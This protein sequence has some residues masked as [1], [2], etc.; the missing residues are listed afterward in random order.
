MSMEYEVTVITGKQ[1]G[2]G[3]DAKIEIVVTGTDGYFEFPEIPIPD[4]WKVPEGQAWDATERF[5]S[6]EELQAAGASPTQNP[7]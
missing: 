2:A 6:D 3:T 5:A 4:E 7:K 1:G